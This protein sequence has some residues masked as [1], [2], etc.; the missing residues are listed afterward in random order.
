MQSLDRPCKPPGGG[1]ACWGRAK[2]KADNR[3]VELSNVRH[4]RLKKLAKKI[5]NLAKDAF[6]HRPVAKA[7]GNAYAGAKT[8]TAKRG[9]QR[10]NR[11]RGTKAPSA[12]REC[13]TLEPNYV[14]ISFPGNRR[15][16]LFWAL[17]AAHLDLLLDV[18]AMGKAKVDQVHDPN[19]IPLDEA[20]HFKEFVELEGWSKLKAHISSI[21]LEMFEAEF[22]PAR[23][24]A[25]KRNKY[26][27]GPHWF[28]NEWGKAAVHAAKNGWGVLIFERWGGDES[29]WCRLERIF[30]TQLLEVKYPGS[31]YT[32]K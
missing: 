21:D 31:V 7:G 30:A 5:H 8:F 1:Q 20:E 19:W 32:L 11:K 13:D 17:K 24:L 18:H 12:L 4:D 26:G 3:K 6:K 28:V 27:L 23:A 15:Q 2:D 29:P 25:G 16:D 9:N 22:D 10:G 14:C